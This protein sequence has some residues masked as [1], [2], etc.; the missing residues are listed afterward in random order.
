MR[1]RAFCILFLFI[2]VTGIT[3]GQQYFRIRADVSVKTKLYTGEQSL[4]LGQVF[5]DRNERKIIYKLTFPAPE[6]IVTADTVTYSIKEGRITNRIF[7][8]SLVEF[9]IFHLALSSSL[10]DYGLQ[11]T[12][13]SIVDVVKEQDMV[14][15][16]WSPP[17]DLEDELGQMKISVKNKQLFGVIFYS[18]EGTITRKQLFEDYIT[19]G[20]L[21]FPGKIVEISQ[22]PEG[23]SY[24]VMTFKNLVIDEIGH[25]DIYHYNLT[26]L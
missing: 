19:Q 16:T 14:I 3:Y 22:S 20:G 7:S 13:F 2:L 10:P 5:Y 21:V 18:P 8:P 15:T 12:Q 4:T 1:I 23:E 6:D 11:K 9:S 26:D 25:S 24:Q 17:K